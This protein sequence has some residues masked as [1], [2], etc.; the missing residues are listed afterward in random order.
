MI[1]V[2]RH[3]DSGSLIII[4]ITFVLFVWALFVKGFAHDMLL[5]AAVFLVSIK[6][7][8]MAYKDVEATGAVHD[9][10]DKIVERL[11][12]IEKNQFGKSED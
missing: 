1:D 11:G 12:E 4:S 9:K 7:V 2:K 8:V 3:F 5:E 10:L 6:L